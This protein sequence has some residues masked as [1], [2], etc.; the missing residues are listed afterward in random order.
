MITMRSVHM[1]H[2]TQWSL[3]NRSSYSLPP[4]LPHLCSKL[5]HY[6]YLN[7]R[8]SLI[9]NCTR[10]S[11]GFVADTSQFKYPFSKKPRH[12]HRSQIFQTVPVD[13]SRRAR[14]RFV[15]R[16]NC[17]VDLSSLTNGNRTFDKNSNTTAD[18]KYIIIRLLSP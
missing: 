5:N 9:I 14:W 7:H 16:P 4:F 17:S 2:L 3:V 13:G 11:L 6:F 1:S 12:T 15:P 8:I 18:N 10:K